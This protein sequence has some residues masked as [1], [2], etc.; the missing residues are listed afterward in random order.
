MLLIPMM[1]GQGLDLEQ[2]M[3]DRV[4]GQLLVTVLRAR[5][6]P[7]ADGLIGAGTSDPFCSVQVGDAWQ[8]GVRRWQTSVQRKQLDPYWGESFLVPLHWNEFN[9]DFIRFLVYDYDLA[10]A[11]DELGT[12]K[13]EL[14]T[15]IRQHL[16][17]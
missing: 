11:N 10:S 8:L 3:P 13:V 2:N 7:A 17:C 9:S 16:R 14:K 12:A 5:N 1:E 6:L 4:V 15:A